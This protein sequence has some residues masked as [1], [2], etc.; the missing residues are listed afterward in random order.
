MSKPTCE[1]ILKVIT[2]QYLDSHDFNGL[3]IQKLTEIFKV[4]WKTIKDSIIQLVD[5]ELVG[6]IFS[7]TEINIHII[8]IGFESKETQIEKL[9]SGNF[10]ACLYPLP[11]HLKNAVKKENYPGRPYVLAMA[12]GAPQLSFRSF[13]LSVMEYYR[14]DPR[15]R[16]E[17]D[18]ISGIISIKD[19]YYE[20]D[21]VPE[22]DQVLLETF[23]I[24]YDEENNR[25]VAVFVRYLANLCPE[26][27]QIW[28]ARE[29]DGNYELHPDYLR[30][31]ILGEWGRG[32]SVFD[33]F[34]AEISLINK[35]GDAMGRPK[36][37]RTNYG[38]YGENKPK[39]FGFL[40]RPTLAEYNRFIHLLDKMLSEDINK[41]FFMDNIQ[42]QK[43]FERDDGKIVVQNKGTLSMLDEWIRTY[44]KTEDWG[45]WDKAIKSFKKIRKLRQKPAHSFNKDEFDQKYIKEQRE[46]IKRAYEGVRT[47]RSMLQ[48]HRLVQAANIEIP[49][50]LAE[51][52]IWAQ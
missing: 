41:K 25:A 51:G 28:H 5:Q 31:T 32:V 23:G 2:R 10:A 36:L 37:F 38:D 13:D 48:N 16:Y 33:A 19:E 49:D 30:N 15:Y 1:H 35:M 29:L 26:H 46:I 9:S 44:F 42:S 24:S 11:K 47:L 18:D 7:D 21:L 4:D 40:I 14:N 20:T 6:A 8:R 39:E 12:L 52:K 45:Y 34:I 43:E 50:W 3:P 22:R 17:N 27:Q